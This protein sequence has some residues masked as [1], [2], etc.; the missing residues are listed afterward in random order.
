MLRPG[1][2]SS[3]R[4]GIVESSQQQ[5]QQQDRGKKRRPISQEPRPVSAVAPPPRKV[6]AYPQVEEFLKESNLRCQKF[7]LQQS[8][9]QI[10]FGQSRKPKGKPGDAKAPDAAAVDVKQTEKKLSP[11]EEYFC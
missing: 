5:Q 8:F 2:D 6:H 4:S 9:R 3:A 10:S 11:W 1:R 7:A